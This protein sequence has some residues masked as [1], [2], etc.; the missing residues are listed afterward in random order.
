MIWIWSIPDNWPNKRIGEYIKDSGTDRFVFR[1]TKLLDINEIICPKVI[2]E[3]DEKYLKGVL[4]N[5]ASLLIVSSKVLEI[6]NSICPHDF[7]TLEANVYIM[8][9]KIEGYFMLNILNAVEIIDKE[10]SIFQ[11][12]RGTDSIMGFDKIVYKRNDLLEHNLVRNADYRSH[13]LV[14]DRLKEAFEKSKIKGI[15]FNVE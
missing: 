15:Q 1:E 2:F 14:S 8:D 11:K 3:C 6:V 13:V 7:Q 4:P 5:N 9:K 12:F 10:K